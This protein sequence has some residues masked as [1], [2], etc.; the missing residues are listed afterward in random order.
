MTHILKLALA[1]ASI[2]SLTACATSIQNRDPS[3]IAAKAYRTTDSYTGLQQT[4]L[5]AFSPF[6]WGGGVRGNAQLQSAEAFQGRDGGAWLDITLRYDTPTPDPG[7]MRVYNKAR[8]A[9]GEEVQI[10]DFAAAVMSCED[11]VS[12]YGTGGYYGSGIYGGGAYGFGRG[13]STRGHYR[14][15]G[16]DGRGRGDD[17]GDGRGDGGGRDVSDDRPRDPG[18]RPNPRRPR[19]VGGDP[20][21]LVEPGINGPRPV[22]RP[23]PRPRPQPTSGSGETRPDP[24]PRPRRTTRTSRPTPKSEPRATSRPTRPTRNRNNRR[25]AIK[26]MHFEDPQSAANA[27]V[28]TANVDV[29]SSASRL[30]PSYGFATGYRAYNY[31]RFGGRGFGRG[32][33]PDREYIVTSECERQ[34]RIRVFVPAQR[35]AAAERYGLSLYFRSNLGDER[36]VIVS[37][38]YVMGYQMATL[39]LGAP[40]PQAALKGQIYGEP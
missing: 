32:F 29:Q 13:R 10:A 14:G 2:L 24:A 34:E 6:E 1:T 38:N 36:P 21:V 18:T 35:L 4:R 8:W 26:G 23:R 16:H 25:D 9:G 15:R 30:R 19:G 40:R 39:H 3:D 37:P 28:L 5:P 7:E 27:A 11:R 12:S 22:V 33:Y 31:G 20:N 17:R